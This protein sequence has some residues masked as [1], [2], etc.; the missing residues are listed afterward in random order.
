MNRT[1]DAVDFEMAVLYRWRAIIEYVIIS[2][3]LKKL[4]VRENGSMVDNEFTRRII[5]NIEII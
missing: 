1:V 3:N 2:I 5:W 4:L